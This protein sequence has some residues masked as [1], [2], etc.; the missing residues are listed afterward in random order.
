MT[1]K[2][3][4][5]SPDAYFENVYASVP[6]P[7][8]GAS[9]KETCFETIGKIKKQAAEAFQID[10]IP[11][12][13]EKLSVT[14]LK[15]EKR[16]TYTLETLS[17]GICKGLSMLCY[18]LIPEKKTGFGIAALCGHGY[19]ARQ[20][21]RQSKTGK[22][23]KIN[24]FDNYQ[25]NFAEALSLDGHTVIVP[26]FIAFGE[27]KLKKDAYKPFYASSCDTVS[28]H[29]LPF[30]F[31]TASL[32]IY[33]AMKCLDLLTERYGCT[34]LGCMGISGG[35]L[36]ALYTSLLDERIQSA[37]VCG[38]INTFRTSILSMW[39]CPDNYI[40]GLAG[41]GDMYDFASA[42]APRR[43]MMQCG[44]ND[45]LFPI[46]G[47]EKAI[48]NISRVYELAGCKENFIPDVFDGKHEVDLPAALEFFRRREIQ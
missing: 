28:H 14:V 12:K 20:I 39:H 17:V 36:V 29:S 21:I 44:R 2:K 4:D 19:G 26:E 18:A 13:S 15:T 11:L 43:L 7:F 24:F 30:G 34:G 37:C 5:F 45:K 16:K 31:S 47:S 40:P 23:R 27:A 35:G 32:R 10:A 8:S 6:S 48:K 9:D 22:Y 33:Q 42:L 38:Y 1:M 25:K 41:I 3:N 46:G